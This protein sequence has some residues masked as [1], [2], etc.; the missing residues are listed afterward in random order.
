[1]RPSCCPLSRPRFPRAHTIALAAVIAG[2]GAGGPDLPA[3]GLDRRTPNHRCVAP[4]ARD[5]PRPARLGET[6]C[7]DAQDP[8]RPAPGLIPYTVNVPLWSDGA[9][10]LR[11]AAVPDGARVHVGADGD[12]ELPVGTV[13]LKTFLI[14]GTPVE[15]RF[16]ARH[17]D[18]TWSG[19]SYEWNGGDATLLPDGGH[20]RRVGD[21]EWQFPTR[22]QC[23][24]CHTDAA[25]GA[26]GLETGQLNTPFDYPGGRRANQITTWAHLGLLDTPLPRPEDLP[27]LPA[28]GD[29]TAP[30][31]ARARAY[32]HVNCANCHRPELV[33]S[34]TVDLRFATPLAATTGCDEAP[35]KGTLGFGADTRVIAPGDPMRSMVALRMRDT[36]SARMPPVASDVVDREGVALVEGWIRG[37]S[38]C[39]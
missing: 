38:S 37:L 2:C 28:P 39:R 18:G 26:L 19:W 15:T 33:D 14:A 1:M 6:G 5:D 24:R 20:R 34:G 36:G 27:R 17:H 30:V 10:K 32:L 13:L 21:G 12:W 29:T 25:G 35:H 3:V 4:A 23:D 11:W 7:F 31:E 9:D 8:T 22:A 16:F